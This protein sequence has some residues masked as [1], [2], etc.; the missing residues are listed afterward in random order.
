LRGPITPATEA[1][2]WQGWQQKLRQKGIVVGPLPL[3]KPARP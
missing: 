3:K 2:E 1:R